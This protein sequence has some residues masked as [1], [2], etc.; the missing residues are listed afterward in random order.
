[1]KRINVRQGGYIGSL[2]VNGWVLLEMKPPEKKYVIRMAITQDEWREFSDNVN[3]TYECL[4][5]K[6]AERVRDE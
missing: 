6:L 3:A 4:D 5:A 1:M 2:I